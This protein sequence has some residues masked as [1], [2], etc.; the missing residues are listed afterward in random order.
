MAEGA[1]EHEEG[2][3]DA[4]DD[5]PEGGGATTI[6]GTAGKNRDLKC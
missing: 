5:V 2:D 3:G 4:V 6:P 1:G